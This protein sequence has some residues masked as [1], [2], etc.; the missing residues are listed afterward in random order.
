M[1]IRTSFGK[2]KW[3]LMAIAYASVSTSV[4][5]AILVRN[6][7]LNID[8]A[9]VTLPGVTV[10]TFAV[11]YANLFAFWCPRCQKNWG[12]LAMQ[13]P[14][15]SLN[16]SIQYCPYCGADVDAGLMAERGSQRV[17]TH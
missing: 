8:L 10:F 2:T 1:T 5:G 13:Y 4:A 14:L 17:S 15:F 3:W 9:T 7:V 12:A 6:N 11:F 16:Q